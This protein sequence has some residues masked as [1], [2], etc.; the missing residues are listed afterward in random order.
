M[1]IPEAPPPPDNVLAGEFEPSSNVLESLLHT[2]GLG[3]WKATAAARQASLENHTTLFD[4][5]RM[6]LFYAR[7]LSVLVCVKVQER[8]YHDKPL[9]LGAV[10]NELDVAKYANIPGLSADFLAT[11]VAKLSAPEMFFRWNNSSA[12]TSHDDMPEHI[13]SLKRS[14]ARTPTNFLGR[15]D[16]LYPLSHSSHKLLKV[17]TR[18]CWKHAVLSGRSCYPIK[19]RTGWRG[20]ETWALQD[21][22][23]SFVLRQYREDDDES[24]TGNKFSHIR[25]RW[26]WPW[27][28]SGI[29]DRSRPAVYDLLGDTYV[30]GLMNGEIGAEITQNVERFIS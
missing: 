17:S 22:K 14:G 4:A 1:R 8:S 25:S 29:A 15:E 11:Q 18:R 23:W 10:L 5:R 2:L 27:S 7:G 26:W 30:H 16:G 9:G 6:E 12:C 24:I 20:D 28:I 19:P 21:S 3:S 13:L